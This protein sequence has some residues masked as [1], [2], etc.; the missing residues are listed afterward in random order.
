[1]SQNQPEKR[2]ECPS[3]LR[4]SRMEVLCFAVMLRSNT[5]HS[6]KCPWLWFCLGKNAAVT[7]VSDR[8]HVVVACVSF[9]EAWSRA[10]LSVLRVKPEHWQRLRRCKA[11]LV[12]RSWLSATTHK[13]AHVGFVKT[14]RRTGL[15]TLLTSPLT[16]LAYV[17]LYENKAIFPVISSL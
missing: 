7:V 1:M 8:I 12:K 16:R 15:T 10:R 13:V 14:L 2:P 17:I 11:C 6:R 3:T 9:D 4:P 5:C